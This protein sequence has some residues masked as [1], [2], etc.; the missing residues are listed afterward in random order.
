MD[1]WTNRFLKAFYINKY[2]YKHYM[3]FTISTITYLTKIIA[4]ITAIILICIY[5]ASFNQVLIL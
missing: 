1:K 3:T 2:L 5:F 4:E